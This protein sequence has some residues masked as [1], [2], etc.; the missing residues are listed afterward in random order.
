VKT[1][2][3]SIDFEEFYATERQDTFRRTPLPVLADRLLEFLRAAGMRCTFFIV[4]EIALRF[5]DAIRAIAAAGHE[6]ACHTHT[7]LPL[8]Q[9]TPASLR[10]DLLRNLDAIRA[11]SPNPVIG[12]RAPILSLTQRTSWAHELLAGLGFKYSSSV[13]PARNPLYGWPEFGPAPRA[14]NGITEVPITLAS[15]GPLRIPIGAGTYFRCLPMP[16]IRS[17][18][19][20]CASR[21]T[22]I[23]GYFHPYDI[24]TAQERVMSRGVNGSRFMNSLLYFNRSRT[25]ERLESILAAGFKIIPYRDIHGH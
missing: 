20:T 2:L 24:D 10:D 7:H 23:A 12:F 1:F 25:L 17:A 15:F 22:P 14:V 19:E 3:F 5:P 9:H 8:D 13:L 18:F 21:D 16:F 4:G 6:L 11:H